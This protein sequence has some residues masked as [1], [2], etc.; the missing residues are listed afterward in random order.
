MTS[1]GAE[2]LMRLSLAHFQHYISK[3]IN[4][5]ITDTYK[6]EV[7]KGEFFTILRRNF[8]DTIVGGSAFT[9]DN[10]N[11]WILLHEIIPNNLL[12]RKIND[13]L[14]TILKYEN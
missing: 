9:L 3:N 11:I 2:E 5:Y 6:L 12:I 10:K 7:F 4:Q 14:A 1:K 8:R 13:D